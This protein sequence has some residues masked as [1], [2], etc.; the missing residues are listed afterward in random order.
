MG[1]VSGKQLS[2]ALQQAKAVGLVEERFKVLDCEVVVRN[3][4]PDEYEAVVQECKDLDDLAYLNKWQEGHV[5]R[6]IVE[7]NGYDLRDTQFVE[8][9]EPDAKNPQQTRTK[10]RELHDWLRRNVLSTW[11]KEAIFTAY[12]KFTDA[13]QQAENKAKAGVVFLVAEESSEE[14]FR[15][16]LGELKEL[17]DEVPPPILQNV[18]QEHG[19]TFYTAPQ[20]VEALREFDRKVTNT[21]VENPEPANQVVTPPAPVQSPPLARPPV[22]PT[23]KVDPIQQVAA[24][25][26]QRVPMNQQPVDVPEMP[27]APV[28]IQEPVTPVSYPSTASA[29]VP[30]GK[31]P[32]GSAQIDEVLR[33]APPQA[34][35]PPGMVP[36]PDVPAGIY[37]SPET[38][39]PAPILAQ[40]GRT[41]VDPTALASIV[42]KGPSSGINP[43]WRPIK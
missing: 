15:R 18:L 33:S 42:E 9:E 12:R 41:Q 20:D 26:R 8:V 38:R 7:I 23:E 2:E 1:V 3:L 6:S 19:Y 10:K 21:P 25:M 28:V 11:S 35:L 34:V 13:V 37:T 36:P 29:P 40:N 22:L 30:L 4:R 17:E 14:K 31:I 16:L 24:I 39:G 43:K 27:K 5:C 32:V